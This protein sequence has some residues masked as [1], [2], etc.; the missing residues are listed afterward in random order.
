[1]ISAFLTGFSYYAVKQELDQTQRTA[2]VSAVGFSLSVGLAKEI[3]D[4]A[5]GK[6]TPSFKDM[7]ADVAG[8]AMGFLLLNISSL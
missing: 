3:Y 8:V 5:S 6:G 1:M 4:A 2:T 7:V